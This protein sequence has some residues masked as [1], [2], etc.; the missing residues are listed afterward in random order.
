MDRRFQLGQLLAGVLIL[1]LNGTNLSAQDAAKP[2]APAP[3]PIAIQHPEDAYKQAMK[4]LD[5]VRK[6]LD[7][8]SDAELNALA[9]GMRKANETCKQ[10]SPA[11]YSGEDLY[12]LERLCALGQNWN[13]TNAAASQ[14][15]KS[16][17]LPHRAHSYAMSLESLVHLGS[18]PEAV[19]TAEKMLHELPYDAVVAQSFWYL[20][21]QLA[22]K[23]D[24]EAEELAKKQQPFL[25]EA[26]KKGVSLKEAYGDATINLG[27]LYQ[28]GMQL[29]FLQRYAKED[30][31]AAQSYADLKNALA[32]VSLPDADDAQLIKKVNTQYALIGKPLPVIDLTSSMSALTS[33]PKILR[34]NG[35][36]VT[37]VLFPEWCV[38]CINM[39]GPLTQFAFR[40]G[41]S[42]FNA[43]GIMIP[44]K[45][46]EGGEAPKDEHL[47]DLKGTPTF[48]TTD[49][50][51]DQLGATDYPFAIVT[52]RT[53]IVR[54]VGTIPSNAFD[55]G[56]YMETT[57][58]RITGGSSSATEA[59]APTPRRHSAP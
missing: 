31:A 22:T 17:D 15:L 30:R 57:L 34:G 52:D 12:Q 41:D 27:P 44:Y 39:M 48:V 3:P 40:N 58:D 33:K 49:A 24:P 54:Y 20:I 7:N 35:S 26:L 13:A 42:H 16:N 9:D 5:L 51:A 4:P 38:Q 45:V 19:H 18:M 25:L 6:N 29:V 46:S 21:V 2:A 10:L 32:E 53:G 11:D 47:K 28:E 43:Y 14:Y 23:F 8:W 50:A 1:A 55:P 59:K 37:V 36:A 56:G